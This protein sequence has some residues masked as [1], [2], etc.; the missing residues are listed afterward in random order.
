[1]Y[2]NYLNKESNNVYEISF[3]ILIILK[4]N[5]EGRDWIAD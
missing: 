2:S 4:N 5:A 1:M 3:E